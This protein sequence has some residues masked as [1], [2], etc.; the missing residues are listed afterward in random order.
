MGLFS[1]KPDPKEVDAF[2][3]GKKTSAKAAEAYVQ[4]NRTCP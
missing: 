1:K 4:Q 2:G 3:R